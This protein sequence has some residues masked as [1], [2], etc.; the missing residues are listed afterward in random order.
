[1]RYTAAI[2]G[3]DS[4]VVTKLDVLD[5]FENIPVCVGYKTA[6]KD[7]V[8]MPP[9]VRGI[10]K[11]EPV[12][13]C[14]PGRNTSTFGVDSY[15]AL[16]AKAKDYI[17]FLE[18]RMGVEI[19]VRFD[20]S[21]AQPDHR[22]EQVEVREADGGALKRVSRARRRIGVRV[23]CLLALASPILLAQ[24]AREIMRRAIEFEKQNRENWINYT[25]LERQFQREYD[26]SNKLKR[27]ILR[28][29][30]VTN[31]E[32]SPYRRL[33]GATTSRSAPR[34]RRPSRRNSSRA[35]R[36]AA[37]RPRNSASAASPSG[38]DGRTGSASPSRNWR[39]P[40]HSK[41]AGEKMVNG[42]LS[43]IIDGRRARGISRSPRR[44]RS[45]RS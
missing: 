24:D 29:Y 15:D 5:E 9:T 32:G 13:E 41:I 1:M 43:W 44:P 33:V 2:N 39:T 10:E 37:R 35:S 12:Y 30:D 18:S 21:G 28:T 19:G 7:V 20:R 45:C 11:L 40:S 14:V 42:R 6:G 36:S 8:D 25:Y 38:G 34:S 17:A 16:P 26:G 3:F 27:D 23:L 4:I 22:A 31:V